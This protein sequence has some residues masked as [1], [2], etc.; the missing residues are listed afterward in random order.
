[1]QHAERTA[2]DCRGRLRTDGEGKY[3]YRAVVPVSYAIPGD[4]GRNSSIV[5]FHSALVTVAE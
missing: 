2:P 4:V 5:V 3:G 1:M